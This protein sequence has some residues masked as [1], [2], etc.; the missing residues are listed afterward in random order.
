M[1]EPDGSSAGGGVPGGRD[2]ALR[3]AP[4]AHLRPDLWNGV[5]LRTLQAWMGHANIVT[6]QRYRHALQ[7]Q[8]GLKS[9]PPPL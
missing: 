8:V 4:P 7:A 3:C 9:V 1:R 2:E 5:D 6:T